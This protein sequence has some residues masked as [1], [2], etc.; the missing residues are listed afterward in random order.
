[1]ASSNDF[2]YIE[3]LK[4][5]GLPVLVLDH[6]IVEESTQISDNCCI[7]NNQTSPDYK[8]KHLSGAGVVY[9]FCNVLD[10]LTQNNYADNYLDLAALG[11][12]ADMMSGLE[13]ENQY[14]WKRGFSSIKNFFFMTIAR[15]QSYS[16]TGKMNASDEDIIE[17][18]ENRITYSEKTNNISVGDL[19]KLGLLGCEESKVKRMYLSEKLRIGSPNGKT[20]LKRLNFL[21]L[22][23]KD[24]EE[25]LNAKDWDSK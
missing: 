18:L 20:L 23:F 15:K 12:C 4:E 7:I 17:A 22:T 10:V 16:I 25:I 19:Y 5:I 14:I 11:I 1:M 9:Q 21:Q 8:N 24:L 13:Y 2:I 6:H 3:Q